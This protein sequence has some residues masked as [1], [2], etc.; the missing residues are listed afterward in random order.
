[1]RGIP[2]TH[3]SGDHQVPAE[4]GAPAAKVVLSPASSPETPVAHDLSETATTTSRPDRTAPASG[5]Q[6]ASPVRAS[7]ITASAPGQAAT[8]DSTP[9]GA[10]RRSPWSGWDDAPLNDDYVPDDLFYPTDPELPGGQAVISEQDQLDAELDELLGRNRYS[11]VDEFEWQ[12]WDGIEQDAAEREMLRRE[13]PPW[14]FL[15]PGGALAAALEVTRPEAMSPM[16]LIELMKAADRLISWGEAIKT[17]ATASFVRQRR[18]EHRESPRPTQLDSRGRPID[19][20]RSWHGEIALALGLSPNT[21]GRRVDTALR[22]TSTLAAT[23]SGLRCGAL[24]WGKALAISEAT[25]ELPDDAARAVQAHVLKRAA[26]QTHRNLL[27][28]LRRQVAK[29]TTAQAADDHRAAVA[30][31]TCKI[32]P[33][34]NG[35]AGLWIVHTADK[36]QQMWITLQAMTTLAKRSTP[37]TNP[38]TNP[39]TKLTA[40]PTANPA[41]PAAATTDANARATSAATTAD[42]V[43]SSAADTGTTGLTGTTGNPGMT[44]NARNTVPAGGIADVPGGGTVSATAAPQAS[45]SAPTGNAATAPLGASVHPAPTAPADA[46]PSPHARPGPD[47]AIPDD[48]TTTG[49]TASVG[50]SACADAGAGA[51]AGIGPSAD[52]DTGA[53]AGIGP[54]AAADTGAGAGIGPSAAADT[55]ADAGIGP[56]ADADTGAGAGIGPSADA[57]TGAGAGIGAGAAGAGAG[58]GKDVRTAE[59]RRADVVADLF[60]HILRNGLDWLGRR[61]PDQHRRRPHIEVV[62]PAS[63]LLGLDDDPAELTGYGPIPA[64]LARRIA[65]DGTWRRLLTDPTN[66]TVLEASTTRHDPGALVTETLLAR[67]P[68]CAWPGCNRTS[69]EC[70]R[71]HLTPFT[72]SGRTT[73]TGMAPYCEYHHVIK[74]THA[75]GWTTTSHHDG[76]I[77][78]TTPTGH[79]YTTVP[80]ARG[81][82]TQQPDASPS[83][84]PRQAAHDRPPF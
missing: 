54:S 37:T 68:V 84:G 14:V 15:P 28:S 24:T 22:L 63:T 35:M 41:A 1:M 65:T 81:P 72:R 62:V 36:I 60:E 10:A 32:V 52:A 11:R 8:I 13:A 77:T 44:C 6:T 12:E 2:G 5:C 4:P 64:D 9:G 17:S 38:T 27:E 42:V 57:D 78:L 21:V 47:P 43:G 70:D 34:P 76:S 3:L 51:G 50:S 80:P 23:H 49:T 83:T 73:L 48:I 30:E 66:G 55:G 19:P 26:R 56:S 53:D 74:D 82:I 61:L 75:W 7:T 29:H 20:E 71:D 79:R 67:H 25:S 58:A 33:L 69:R 16:A 39:T 45:D 40:N 31:R 46:D 18:A 59:Q